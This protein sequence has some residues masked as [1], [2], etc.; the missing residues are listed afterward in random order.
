VRRATITIGLLLLVVL[1]AE[2]PIRPDE[3]PV[4]P[5]TARSEMADVWLDKSVNRAVPEVGT[6]VVFTLRVSNRGPSDAPG[7]VVTDRLPS[8]Y[9]YLADDGGGRYDG[10]TGTWRVG[11]LRADTTSTLRVTVGV[12]PEGN[13]LTSAEVTAAG[14]RDPDSTPG[15]GERNED[16]YAEC[17]TTPLALADLSLTKAVDRE[18]PDV[19]T[20][21]LFTLTVSNGGPSEA[22]GITVVDRLPGGYTYLHDDSSGRYDRGTGTWAVRNLVANATDVLRITALVNPRGEYASEAEITT[23]RS[24]DPDS[25]PGN[26]VPAEDDYAQAL[27][28]P[29]P[30]ADLSLT[31]RVDNPTPEVD[32]VVAFSLVVANAGPS[33]AIGVV[34]TDRLPSGLR[35]LDHE[36]DGAYDPPT[37]VWTVGSLPAGA[38]A[39]LSIRARVISTGDHANTAGI[40]ASDPMDADA[41]G[42][43][44]VR[45]EARQPEGAPAE[46]APERISI[47]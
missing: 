5:T 42:G 6:E 19:G 39:S 37:G 28:A 33:D 34:V 26:A 18:R 45:V 32:T 24:K 9:T 31:Q 14:Q 27:L 16:D 43:E 41:G 4:P 30:V 44:T 25:T 46:S 15:N 17:L 10:R 11:T 22:T 12:N 13:Y 35:Y 3:T 8:G 7:V 38:A 36:G 21:V 47:R 1:E 2:A 40:T 20:T 23:A 29:V